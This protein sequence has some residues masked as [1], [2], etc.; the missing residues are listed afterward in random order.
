MAKLWDSRKLKTYFW[1]YAP[2]RDIRLANNNHIESLTAEHPD[3][4]RD[5]LRCVDSENWHM[6]LAEQDKPRKNNAIFPKQPIK[7][8]RQVDDIIQTIR[9]EFLGVDGPLVMHG[10]GVEVIL[11]SRQVH[12]TLAFNQRS[13]AEFS[14]LHESMARSLAHHNFIDFYKEERIPHVL[15]A[16]ASAKADWLKAA[17]PEEYKRRVQDRFRTMSTKPIALDHLVLGQSYYSREGHRVQGSDRV[18]AKIHYNGHVDKLCHDPFNNKLA[19]AHINREELKA[20]AMQQARNNR[21]SH[22]YLARA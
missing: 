14:D 2:V 1:L 16:S 18:I 7:S 20:R 12:L 5:Q 22:Q 13:K 10:E 4:N 9:S 11:A 21:A 15:L 6:T 19:D 17:D 8:A 3:F